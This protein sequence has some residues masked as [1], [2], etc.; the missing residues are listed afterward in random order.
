MTKI[1]V[2][3]GVAFYEP[4]RYKTYS[5]FWKCYAIPNRQDIRGLTSCV[6]AY[7]ANIKISHTSFKLAM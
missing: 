7:K 3:F 1:V 5:I 4:N 2:L 6:T